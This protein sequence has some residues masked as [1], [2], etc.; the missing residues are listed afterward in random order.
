MV[1]IIKAI[2]SRG[3]LRPEEPLSLTEDQRVRVTIE[4][5]ESESIDRA[6]AIARFRE[7]VRLSRFKS[8]APYPSREEL[9]ER[10]G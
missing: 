5:L 10:H 9:H 1:R 8:A 4:T 6:S 2:F 3:V 7:S